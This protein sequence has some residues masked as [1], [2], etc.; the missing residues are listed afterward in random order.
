MAQQSSAPRSLR[1]IKLGIGILVLLIPLILGMGWRYITQIAP[2][3]APPA[4]AAMPPGNVAE[5]FREI[6][7]KVHADPEFQKFRLYT[8]VREGQERGQWIIAT[9]EACR[10]AVEQQRAAL[11]Q[12]RQLLGKPC[13]YP[14]DWHVQRDDYTPYWRLME[15]VRAEARLLKMAGRWRQAADAY[16]EVLQFAQTFQSSGNAEDAIFSVSLP[17]YVLRPMD[18][19]L[20]RCDPETAD[21]IGQ[22]LQRLLPRQLSRAELI[23]R[24]RHGVLYQ[25]QQWGRSD[26]EETLSWQ[27]G[28]SLR[29]DP[30]GGLQFDVPVVYRQYLRE[31]INHLYYRFCERDILEDIRRYYDTW[32]EAVLRAPYRGKAPKHPHPWLNTLGL[33]EATLDFQPIGQTLWQIM[34][35]KAALV[36]YR[37]RHNGALPQSLTEL[38]LSPRWTTDPFRAEPLRLIRQT[39]PRFQGEVYRLYSVGENSK[40]DQGAFREDIGLSLRMSDYGRLFPLMR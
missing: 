26:P 39:R 34:V 17:Y 2:P 9:P 8:Y 33:H 14:A 31:R 30:E 36:S 23:E 27:G 18:D 22:Q 4:D 20:D 21:Y 3:I 16:L 29:A 38:N 11:R 28:I 5:R 35:V 12:F 25:T 7:R 1:W 13:V 6:A 32:H 40:D 37:A 15:L 10:A 19:L 24:S